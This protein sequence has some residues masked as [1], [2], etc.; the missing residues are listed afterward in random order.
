MG[1]FR[2]S[3]GPLRASI[4]VG[5]VYDWVLAALIFWSPPALL[6][7]FGLPAPADP[8]HFRF[9]ALPL[10]ALPFFYLLAWH[11][12]D[13]HSGVIGAMIVARLTGFVYLTLYGGI[14]GEPAA[15]ALFGLGDLAFALA[16]ALLARRA[17]FAR[18]DLFPL[19][20]SR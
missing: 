5:S 18:R 11:D 7:F 1:P 17:G 20:T 3:A 8:F 4:L 16:H 12:P 2:A 15:F 6:S 19:F 13:R 14:R 10:V 9:A